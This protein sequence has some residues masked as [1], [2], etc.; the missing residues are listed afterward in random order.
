MRQ[1]VAE[2][3]LFASVRIAVMHGG[4]SMELFRLENASWYF[5]LMGGH[6]GCVRAFPGES[7]AVRASSA[8]NN[9]LKAS[10]H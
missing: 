9:T 6:T 10:V 1:A 4:V 5:V 7:S 8:C 3:A 2:I